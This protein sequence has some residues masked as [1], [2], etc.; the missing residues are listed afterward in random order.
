MFCIIELKKAQEGGEKMLYD[1]QKDAF[2][3]LLYFVDKMD[4]KI[5]ILLGD[6]RSG[7]TSLIV[8]LCKKIIDNETFRSATNDH[9]K[10]REIFSVKLKSWSLVIERNMFV[11][12][13]V[14]EVKFISLSDLVDGKY[15]INSNSLVI[16]DDCELVVGYKSTVIDVLKT[17]EHIANNRDCQFILVLDRDKLKQPPCIPA[18][19]YTIK[20]LETI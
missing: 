16:V 1:N 12:Q 17:I 8:E 6:R 15:H 20:E 3:G 14:S 11:E 4:R 18:V 19:I 13:G 2:N 5:A 9:Y 7:R 10:H